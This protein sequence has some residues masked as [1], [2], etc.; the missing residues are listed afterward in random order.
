MLGSNPVEIFKEMYSLVGEYLHHWALMESM[1]NDAIG[2]VLGLDA[3]QTAV[4]CSNITFRSKCHILKT[5][6][7]Y[8]PLG[9]PAEH[10]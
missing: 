6:I 8:R 4:V 9:T 10:H 1:M 3:Y 2:E 5:A 7:Q